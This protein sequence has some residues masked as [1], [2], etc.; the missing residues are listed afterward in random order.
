VTLLKGVEDTSN[1]SV[2]TGSGNNIYGRSYYSIKV[3]WS[4]PAYGLTADTWQNSPNITDLVQ[5]IVNK[6][7]WVAGNYIGFA[8]WGET[9]GNSATEGIYDYNDDS[10]FAPKLYV[11]WT[12]S[13]NKG[14][15]SAVIGSTP[16]YTNK[17]S[18]PFTF[19]LNQNQCQNVTWWVNATGSTGNTH[20]FFAYANKT[21]NMNINNKTSNVNITII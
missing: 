5:Y 8:I 10:T 20:T 7:T 17:S 16:F 21:S 11:Q 1:S 14:I 18:N 15:I 2:F 12:S 3:N 4:I 6:D 19:N 9:S 13:A